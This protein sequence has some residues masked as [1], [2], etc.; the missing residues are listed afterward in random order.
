VKVGISSYTFTWAVGVPGHEPPRPLGHLQLLGLA[1]ELGAEVVQVAD[2]LPLHR[3]SETEL[4]AFASKAREQHLSVEVGT[5]GIDPGHL[6]HYLELAKR[7]GS[8]ILRVVVSDGREVTPEEVVKTLSPLKHKFK[9]SEVTLAI[10]NHDSLPT[11][12]LVHLVEALGTDWVGICLDTV[13]S[14]GALEG[15]TVVVPALAP[16]A[17]NVHVKD[18]V[19]KR[20]DHMMGFVVEGAPAGSGQLD[21]PWLID[22]LGGTTRDL[23][24][25]IELWTPPMGTLDETI[26]KEAEWAHLS[27]QYLKTL[28]NRADS[29]T[30]AKP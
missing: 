11:R 18:F 13:N 26:R 20:V 7:F 4:D 5:R 9:S 1:R 16:F 25:I 12:D 15:P 2:N 23:S 30:Q 22:S 17:V 8:R 28:F 6:A 21:I 10:E 14:F 27:V 19:V 24:A 3:L 29:T